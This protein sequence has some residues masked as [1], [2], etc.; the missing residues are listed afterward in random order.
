ML[1]RLSFYVLTAVFAASLFPSS[2]VQAESKVAVPFIQGVNKYEPYT[3]NESLVWGNTEADTNVLIYI[4]GSYSGHARITQSAGG[5]LDKFEYYLGNQ[6]LKPGGHIVMAIAQQQTSLVLSPPST[7]FKFIVPEPARVPAPTLVWPENG[8]VSGKQKPRVLGLTVSGTKVHFFV[9]G[10]YQGETGYLH[11]ESGTAN[12]AYDLPNNLSVGSHTLKAVTEDKQGRRSELFAQAEFKVEAPLPA[13]IITEFKVSDNSFELAGVVK[14]DLIVK[15]YVD[16][17]EVAV[18]EPSGHPSGTSGFVYKAQGLTKGDYVVYTI[19]IDQK[20]KTSRW[21]DPVFFGITAALPAISDEAASEDSFADEAAADK[22][23]EREGSDAPVIVDGED[24][25]PPEE[26]NGQNKEDSDMT[27]DDSEPESEDGSQEDVDELIS[28]TTANGEPDPSGLI[29]E[30]EQSQLG[31]NLVIFL[32][33][34]LAV[35]IWIV[36]VNRELI[37]EKKQQEDDQ[38]S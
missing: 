35:I 13:P 32:A 9:D 11:H 33:F 1:K 2:L 17:R 26:E 5:G 27:V 16:H 28:T 15:V 7:E 25:I 23:S 10:V 19:A 37:K 3:A 12:F 6:D 29:N 24:N 36:W 4:D 22:T 21:S 18:L 30:S 34:L 14:N 38:D 20:G 31:W 8:D